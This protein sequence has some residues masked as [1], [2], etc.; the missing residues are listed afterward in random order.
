MLPIDLFRQPM[1][2]LFV[3]SQKVAGF[4]LENQLFE[5]VQDW[6]ARC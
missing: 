4:E 5:Q 6:R 3:L 2:A 1:F